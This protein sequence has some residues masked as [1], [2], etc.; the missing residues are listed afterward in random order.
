[1]ASY[2]RNFDFRIPPEAENRRAR[3]FLTA[4]GGTIS[5]PLGTGVAI[6]APVKRDAGNA[7]PSQFP[8]ANDITLAHGSQAPVKGLSGILVYEH[9]PAA[10]AG[11]DPFLTTFSDLGYAPVGKLVQVVSGIDVKVVFTNTATSTFL[12][13]TTYAGRKMVTGIGI[14]TPTLVV[15]DLLTPGTGNDTDG[16][17]DETAVA[18]NAWLVVVAVDNARGEVEAQMLF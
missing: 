4:A 8:G 17:W 12:N 6:G 9:A 1:M 10:Y 3:F 13:T 16:Y 5:T 2:G 15:G 18:A 11:Y 7:A 14:A